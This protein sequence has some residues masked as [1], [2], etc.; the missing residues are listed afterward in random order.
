V[1]L[2]GDLDSWPVDLR[3]Q[4]GPTGGLLALDLGGSHPECEIVLDEGEDTDGT[5]WT[6]VEECPSPPG[7]WSSV[8]G[9]TWVRHE[10][11]VRGADALDVVGDD[12]WL[13]RS[14]RRHSSLWRSRDG[15]DWTKVDL[16]ALGPP[17]P[18]DLDW[19]LD[20]GVPV[21]VRETTIL[22]VTWRARRTEVEEQLIAV[23]DDGAAW[24]V[25]LPGAP[26]PR[27]TPGWDGVRLFGASAAFV[28]FA[29]TED[30]RLRTWHSADGRT[31]Q[32][33][34]VLRFDD[35]TARVIEL[36]IDSRAGQPPVVVA[37]T[38]G[39]AWEST[40]GRTWRLA[41]LDPEGDRA[42]PVPAGWLSTAYGS[43]KVRA[44]DSEWFELGEG[45]VPNIGSGAGGRIGDTLVANFVSRRDGVP[46]QDLWIIQFETDLPAGAAP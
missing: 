26:L 43:L 17:E 10:L 44:P 28:A 14:D 33:G 35:R 12:Y 22:P 20:L 34:D 36:S 4:P 42:M 40:D 7:L 18:A 38:A 23:I 2:V 27:L 3:P 1:H 30:D 41:E 5:G 45:I 31:W 32:E 29:S 21:S 11:P 8:D 9:M 39:K 16:S 19:S 25:P 24:P 13:R 37:Y 6:K 15:I 46:R